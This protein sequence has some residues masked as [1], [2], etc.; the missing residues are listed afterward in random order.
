MDRNDSEIGA[1]ND[2]G[3]EGLNRIIPSNPAS[4]SEPMVALPSWFL[5]Q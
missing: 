5:L 2:Q 1:T 4:N 3:H